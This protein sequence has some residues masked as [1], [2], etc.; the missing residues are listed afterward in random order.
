MKVELTGFLSTGDDASPGNYGYLDQV[1]ALKWVKNNIQAFGG[2][3]E[4]VRIS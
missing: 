2:D 1:E 3:P 4:K